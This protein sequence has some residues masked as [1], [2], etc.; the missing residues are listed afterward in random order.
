LQR[1]LF[2]LSWHMYR[3]YHSFG[4]MSAE[5]NGFQKPTGHIFGVL[6][7][8]QSVL[9]QN[10]KAHITLCLD[11]HAGGKEIIEG[12]KAGRTKL[13]YDIMQD[14]ELIQV[15]ATKHPNVE[16]VGNP[17]AEADLVMHVLAKWYESKGDEVVIFSGDDDMLQS[18]SPNISIYR[19]MSKDGEVWITP[20]EY[21]KNERLVSKYHNC[22]IDRLPEFRALIG[23]KSDNITGIP[24]IPR[25]LALQLASLL[26]MSSGRAIRQTLKRA[27]VEV[28]GPGSWDKYMSICEV[29]SDRLALN[30]SVMKLD[31][32][33]VKRVVSEKDFSDIIPQLKLSKW[34]NFLEEVSCGTE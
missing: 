16:V 31:K 20:E 25:K 3:S 7:S 5:V 17:N 21:H 22:P 13:A 28:E 24:R 6:S 30:Y 27:R 33:K 11:G 4:F 29:E 14:T 12:Y 1:Y 8:I 10:P 2:D 23:D 9:K 15:L 34:E 26:D 19:G 18:L 32:C